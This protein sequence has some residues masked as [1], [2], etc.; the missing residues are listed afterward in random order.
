M[1][2]ILRYIFAELGRFCTAPPFPKG[3]TKIKLQSFC[4]VN[5]HTF[6]ILVWPQKAANCFLMTHHSLSRQ[7]ASLLCGD[8]GEFWAAHSVQRLSHNPGSHINKVFHLKSSNRRDLWKMTRSVIVSS[9]SP[10]LETCINSPF[11]HSETYIYL[12]YPNAL[13]SA[14]SML[15]DKIPISKKEKII[16]FLLVIFAILTLSTT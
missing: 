15:P 4:H 9:G 2:A 12:K 6:P 5:M 8:A 1:Y 3:S 13:W 10:W 11:T 7:K 16:I 14:C